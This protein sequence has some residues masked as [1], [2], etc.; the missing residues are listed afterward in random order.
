MVIAVVV[1]E[2]F[3]CGGANVTLR[4]VGAREDGPDKLDRRLD[5]KST[6]S[7]L[8]LQSSRVT[9]D[10]PPARLKSRKTGRARGGEVARYVRNED[11][12]CS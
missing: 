10:T 4:V 6:T 11:K 1:E 5:A 12:T 9:R 8:S 3:S 2:K 7:S